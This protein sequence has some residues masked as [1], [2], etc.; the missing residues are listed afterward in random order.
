[1]LPWV[2]TQK[3]VVSLLDVTSQHF[4]KNLYE[5]GMANLI[6]IRPRIY[7]KYNQMIVHQNVCDRSAVFRHGIN[8]I[9]VFCW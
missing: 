4:P 9:N 1:M 5:T 6:S 8:C 2:Q 3:F 7:Y